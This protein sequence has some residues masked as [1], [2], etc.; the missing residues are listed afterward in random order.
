MQKY[1]LFLLG[2]EVTLKDRRT[3]ETESSFII[4]PFPGEHPEDLADV[5]PVIKNHYDR[6][7]YTVQEIKHQESKV[8]EID[9]KTAYDAAPTAEAYAYEE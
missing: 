6:L 8:K 7:G 1:L 9:L 4:V 2:F 3:G 5:H